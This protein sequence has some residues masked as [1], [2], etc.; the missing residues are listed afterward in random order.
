MHGPIFLRI[1]D[2]LGT[3]DEYF[4]TRNGFFTIATAAICMLAYGSPTDD[5]D[6]Y[7]RV[8]EST[9]IDV[10]RDLSMPCTRFLRLGI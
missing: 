3:R 7:I 4:R 6:D 10:E 5:G 2:A 9:T 1:V 8:G